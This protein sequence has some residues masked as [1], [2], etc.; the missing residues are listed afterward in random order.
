MSD[1]NLIVNFDKKEYLHPEDF[2]DPAGIRNFAQGGHGSV[3][4]AFAFLL[5]KP[6]R[7][8]LSSLSERCDPVIEKS[9]GIEH[10]TTIELGTTDVWFKSPQWAGRWCGDRVGIISANEYGLDDRLLSFSEQLQATRSAL[11]FD[12]NISSLLQS[13]MTRLQKKETVSHGMAAY[14]ENT[15]QQ[16]RIC[17]NYCSVHKFVLQHYKNISNT[18]QHMLYAFDITK[19]SV[20][21]FLQELKQSL[22]QQLVGEYLRFKVI[23]HKKQH[24]RQYDLTWCSPDTLYQFLINIPTQSVDLAKE[25]L[26]KQTITPASRK[27]IR[28]FNEYHPFKIATLVQKLNT[29]FEFNNFGL[30]PSKDYLQAALV[31][32]KKSNGHSVSDDATKHLQGQ[33]SEHMHGEHRR[34]LQLSRRGPKNAASTS[35][36]AHPRATGG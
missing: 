23:K 15:R 17:Q 13:H 28:R 10:F 18:W 27:I 35:D 20:E 6:T 31:L 26:R 9:D 1:L 8:G 4:Q 36:I 25:W 12:Y 2:A 3:M 5:D 7:Q 11:M 24:R 30:L 34:G 21:F 22:G 14:E 16:L 32:T 33:L 19:H 29:D